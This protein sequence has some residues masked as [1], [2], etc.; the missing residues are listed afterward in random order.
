MFW[1]STFI[2]WL[3]TE[4]LSCASLEPPSSAKGS[5]ASDVLSASPLAGFQLPLHPQF[6]STQL[7]YIINLTK[8]LKKK[9]I[10]KFLIFRLENGSQS[11]VISLFCK[12]FT[13]LLPLKIH[14]ICKRNF[15]I[16]KVVFQTTQVNITHVKHIILS[17]PPYLKIVRIYKIVRISKQ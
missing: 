15:S 16:L 8:S 6:G 7:H 3:S 17:T 14:Q 1:F 4:T 5:P 12:S 11:I 9:T 10:Q 13:H 2:T